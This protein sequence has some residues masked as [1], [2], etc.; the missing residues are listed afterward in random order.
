MVAFT[1]AYK[2]AQTLESFIGAPESALEQSETPVECFVHS[3]E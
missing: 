1:R 3:K 2:D